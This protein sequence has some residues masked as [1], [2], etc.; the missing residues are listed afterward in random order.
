MF[1]IADTDS[2]MY[3]VHTVSIYEDFLQNPDR[4]QYM[5]FSN[6]PRDHPLYDERNKM[7]PGMWKDEMCGL[8][9]KEFIGLRSKCYSI[10]SRGKVII[11]IIIFYSYKQ[12]TIFLYIKVLY[13]VKKS[14]FYFFQRK[15]RFLPD[16]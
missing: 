4:M 11:A 14:I 9:I 12:S 15:K 3:M 8:I 5:D 2:L 6:L 1:Y 16:S 10:L 13:V 7:I